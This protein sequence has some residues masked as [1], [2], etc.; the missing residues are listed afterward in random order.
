MNRRS[1]LKAWSVFYDTIYKIKNYDLNSQD[2]FSLKQSDVK[3]FDELNEV[4]LAMTNK[5]K[6]DYFNLKEYTENASHEIQTPLAIINAKMELLLQS[7]DMKENQYKAVSDAYEAC[8]RLSRLNNSLILLSKIEN[9]QFP[10]SKQVDS[11]NLIDTLLEILED[12]ILSKKIVVKKNFNEP[13]FIQMNPYLAEIL[14]SNLIKNA[15]RHNI[16]GGKIIMEFSEN[17]FVISNTGFKNKIDTK[18]LFKRFHKSSSSAESLGLGLAIVLKICEVYG[19]SIDYEY[20]NDMHSMK[21]NF[22]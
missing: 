20:E 3:E 11:L 18:V 22:H 16:D 10:E 5:I 21:I 15:I 8:T 17:Q 19:F 7:G 14:F 13:F 4:L 6:T 12:L 9:R 2:L 1:T